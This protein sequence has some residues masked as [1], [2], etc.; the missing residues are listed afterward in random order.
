M[1]IVNVH[2]AKTQLSKLIEKVLSGREVII[3]K[4]GRPVVRLE[5]I[6][7]KLKKRVGGQWKNKIS[8]AGDFDTLPDQILNAFLGKSDESAN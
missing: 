2:Q 5:P 6:H 1:E 8:V 4:A 7:G 3:A